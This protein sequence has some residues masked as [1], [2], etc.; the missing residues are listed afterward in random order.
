MTHSCDAPDGQTAVSERP[1]RVLVLLPNPNIGGAERIAFSLTSYLLET[2]RQVDVVIL[3]RG[4]G[5]VWPT[6]AGHSR[7]RL[8]A[9][10]AR[11]ESSGFPR[12]VHT[13]LRLR[14]DGPY[15]VVYTTHAHMNGFAS[16]AIGLGLLRT[17]RLVSRETTLVFDRFFGL[18][19][20]LYRLYYL[21]YRHQDLLIFQ[22]EEM[23][24]SLLRRIRLPRKIAHGVLPNPVHIATID[25]ALAAGPTRRREQTEPVR[26][27]Y[28]GRLIPLKRVGMLLEALAQFD[29]RNWTLRVLGD[30]PLRASLEAEASRLGIAD[31]VEFVGHTANPYASFAE[32]DVG[33]LCSEVEGFPNVLLEMMAS[34]TK[35][36]L[37][38]DC[39]ASVRHLPFVEIVAPGDSGTLADAV[40]RAIEERPDRH[41]EYR[42]YIE[43]H[44]SVSAFADAVLGRTDA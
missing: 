18:K 8:F 10:K 30:G 16:L 33:V 40:R 41:L 42:R 24:D 6:L 31:R 2:G 3:S 35:H 32:A 25:A 23:R 17:R 4:E 29:L 7:F 20:W 43:Q 13:L 21:F 44:R 9:G 36:V 38:T 5:R 12:L 11:S 26:I 37:T 28:C 27:V 22:T 15:D 14:R 19:R 1:L 34:G 39:T